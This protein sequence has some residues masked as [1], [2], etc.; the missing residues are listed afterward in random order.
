MSHLVCKPGHLIWTWWCVN[1]F[2]HDGWIAVHEPKVFEHFGGI[3]RCC[4]IVKT[5]VLMHSTVGTHSFGQEN[6]VIFRYRNIHEVDQTKWSQ[7][8][9]RNITIS[10]VFPHLSGDDLTILKGFLDQFFQLLSGNV[11]SCPAGF[12]NNDQVMIKVEILLIF[13]WSTFEVLLSSNP[14]HSEFSRVAN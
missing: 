4:E 14:C 12:I 2:W 7:R 13:G 5:Q 1:F 9:Q 11:C 10:A 6:D 8:S 3:L